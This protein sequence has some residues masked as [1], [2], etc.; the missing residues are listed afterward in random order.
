[1]LTQQWVGA[2]DGLGFTE[3]DEKEKHSQ[4]R[5]HENPHEKILQIELDPDLRVQEI[6]LVFLKSGSNAT[7]GKVA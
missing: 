5:R 4:N 6:P 7:A 3:E 1:M 2:A